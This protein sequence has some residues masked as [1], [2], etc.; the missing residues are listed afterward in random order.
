[1]SNDQAPGSLEVHPRREGSGKS[2]APESLDQARKPS[3]VPPVIKEDSA[4][5]SPRSPKL[6]PAGPTPSED[7]FS[8]FYS[9]F[10]SLINRLSAPLAFAG[11]P[12]ISEEPTPAAGAATQPPPEPAPRKPRHRPPPPLAEPDLSKIYS[13]ATLRSLARD[14]HGPSDSFYVVPTSGHTASYASILNH[15]NKEKR[16]MAAS[17]HRSDIDNEDGEDDDDFV[18]ARES[19]APAPPLS[20][21]HRRR[22]G[23]RGGRGERDLR[24]A[25]EE[26]QLEN[27]SL[28]DVLDKVSK[29]L[30]AF[31]LNS[32]TSH[33]ALAQSLRLQRPGSPMSSSGGGG[34][35]PAPGGEEALRRRNRE[36][37]EQLAE[38][39]KRMA[40]LERDHLKLQQTVEQYRER[41]EKLKAGAKKRREAQEQ[42]NSGEGSRR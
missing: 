33:L 2:T 31:E 32:Q 26:L 42:A 4:G 3:W 9:T 40:E 34:P 22:P 21:T 7:G 14:G 37:E 41:W 16:R 38:V 25:L 23:S 39:G 1:M 24:N 19:Q 35:G 8:R 17:L 30:H 36:L 5:E 11:L 28:K 10:G 15:E 20:P 29:R 18:D 6:E 12:L 27:A 13:R